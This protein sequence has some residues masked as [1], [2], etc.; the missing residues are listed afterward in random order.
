MNKKLA[1]VVVEINFIKLFFWVTALWMILAYIISLVPS[2]KIYVASFGN[3]THAQ[4]TGDY[5]ILLLITIIATVITP[6]F[7]N[8]NLEKIIA[9]SILGALGLTLLI[10][11]LVTYP[12]ASTVLAWTIPTG[13]MLVLSILWILMG[14]G[15]LDHNGFRP[16]QKEKNKIATAP[17]NSEEDNSS[18]NNLF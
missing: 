16:S 4:Q 11:T 15:I 3:D 8:N 9:G 2:I 6:V 18:L 14:I 10:G 7:I 17:K 1:N 12:Q 5:G 13:V